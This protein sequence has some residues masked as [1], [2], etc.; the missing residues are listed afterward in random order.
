MT[1]SAWSRD[2][3]WY[4]LPLL[5][6]YAGTVIGFCLLGGE[7]DN[8]YFQPLWKLIPLAVLGLYLSFCLV[9][10]GI[11]FIICISPWVAYTVTTECIEASRVRAKLNT[12]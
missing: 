4:H 8:I 6:W 2:L 1:Y 12:V 7:A 3:R 9:C 5:V 11:L 10:F